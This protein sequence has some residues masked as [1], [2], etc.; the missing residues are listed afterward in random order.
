MKE[1][2]HVVD[3]IETHPYE[4]TAVR[5]VAIINR[6]YVYY[7]VRSTECPVGII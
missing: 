3:R 1:P 6:A 5:L 2:I 7:R 4:W